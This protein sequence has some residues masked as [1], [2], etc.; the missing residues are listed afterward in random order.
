MLE[1]MKLIVLMIAALLTV[2]MVFVALQ[3]L[4]AI[5]RRTAR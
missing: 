2:A 3:R 5:A 4:T 1:R